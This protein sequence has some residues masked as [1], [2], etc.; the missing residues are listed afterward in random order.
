ME[1]VKLNLSEYCIEL[2]RPPLFVVPTRN[3]IQNIG[4][5]TVTFGEIFIAKFAQMIKTDFFWT[6]NVALIQR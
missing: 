4:C 2:D 6:N 1:L 3:T 5:V